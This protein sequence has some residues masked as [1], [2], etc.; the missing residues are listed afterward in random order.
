[1]SSRKIDKF[2]FKPTVID[3]R[4]THLTLASEAINFRK[5]GIEFAS[6]VPL[7]RWTEMTVELETPRDGKR[8]SCTG[9]VVSCE[10][11]RQSGY[12]VSLLFTKLDRQ[13]QARLS[14][15]AYSP[16]A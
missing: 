11:N 3:P 1:M 12:A 6:P 9:I 8:F 10:G 2:D 5:N 14:Q 4:Q 13:S 16:L 7:S 15:M